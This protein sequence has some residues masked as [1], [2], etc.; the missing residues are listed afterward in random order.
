VTEALTGKPPRGKRVHAIDLLRLLAS[1]QMIAGHTIGALLAPEHR[2]GALFETWTVARGL[3]AVAFMFAA[4]AAF[5]LVA[6]DA[7][8]ERA[9]RRIVRA[10]GLVVL[11]YALHPPVGALGGDPEL[12]AAAWRE[13]F[14]VDVLSAIGVTLL[15]LELLL[16]LPG[17]VF[18]TGA[19]ALVVIFAAPAASTLEPEGVLLPFTDYLSRRAGSLFPLAP[20]S[21]FLLAGASLGKALF[22]KPRPTLRVATVAALVLLAGT[23]L[24][25]TTSPP[26]GEAYYA[27]PALSL[28]RLGGV[29][30]LTAVLGL[31][32]ERV[33]ELPRVVTILAGPSLFL[34]VAHLLALYVA[35]IGLARL[36][37]PTLSVGETAGVAIAMVIASALGALLFARLRRRPA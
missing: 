5:A 10:L 11:G 13:L 27:W 25:T 21:G 37:G 35:G 33:L 34:Y 19:L 14:A 4:G 30:A 1:V 18:S 20:F 7:P 8:P 12:A 28:M 17:F 22:Q 24:W 26:P 16:R 32:T 3:T 2:S 31:A 23:A 9:R 36:V 6:V 29:L 15:L